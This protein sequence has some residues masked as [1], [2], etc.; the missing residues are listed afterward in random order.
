MSQICYEQ[1]RV[2]TAGSAGSAT[3]SGTTVP[4]Q[5][6][7]LDVY[8]NYHASAPA[9]TDVSLS[10]AVFGEIFANDNSA[11]DVWLT[12]SRQITDAASADTGLYDLVP[13]NGVLTLSVDGCNELTDALVATIRYVTP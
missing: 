5:G 4:I 11:T 7:L 6:F 8:L 2:T 10:D 3:G 9:T 1:V 13:I 12:P